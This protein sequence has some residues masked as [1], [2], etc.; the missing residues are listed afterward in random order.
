MGPD[1]EKLLRWFDKKTGK[2]LDDEALMTGVSECSTVPPSM[3][4][5]HRK[6]KRKSRASR[7]SLVCTYL[8]GTEE[9]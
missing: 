6:F 3:Q 1:I 9:P 4:E 7:A 2:K 8:A 5:A